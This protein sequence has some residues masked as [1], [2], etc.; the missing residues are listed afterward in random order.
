M[1]VDRF[2][3]RECRSVVGLAY[4]LSGSRLGAE[5]LAPEAFAA[6]Y[7]SWDRIGDYDKP[8]AWVRRLLPS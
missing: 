4:V 7:R 2:Y 3:A 6:A 1:E 8:G 5:D